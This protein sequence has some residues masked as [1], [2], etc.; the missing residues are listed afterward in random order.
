[1]SSNNVYY[2]NEE[3]EIPAPQKGCRRFNPK[4]QV[5]YRPC[6]CSCGDPYCWDPDGRPI[7]NK[8]ALKKTKDFREKFVIR[9]KNFIM[10]SSNA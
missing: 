2:D 5:Q 8:R 10:E 7:P 9:T 1:M 6:Y 3:I 4:T